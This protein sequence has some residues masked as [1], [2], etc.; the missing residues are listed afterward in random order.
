MWDLIVSVPDHCLSFYFSYFL[1][2]NDTSVKKDVPKIKALSLEW[3]SPLSNCPVSLVLS[4]LILHRTFRA[5]VRE[6]VAQ[7]LS[8]L[9]VMYFARF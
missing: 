5:N 3:Y 9:H 2:Y 1:K 7:R 4:I 6:F 8:W